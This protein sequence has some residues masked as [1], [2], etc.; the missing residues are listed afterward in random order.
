M[1]NIIEFPDKDKEREEITT[2]ILD[3]IATQ[4]QILEDQKQEIR[5]QREELENIIRLRKFKIV[6]NPE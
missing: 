1:T 3:D 2:A 6:S 4:I 5:R